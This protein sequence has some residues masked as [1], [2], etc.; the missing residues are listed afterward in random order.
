MWLTRVWPDACASPNASERDPSTRV[1][2]VLEPNILTCVFTCVLQC[3]SVQFGGDV[4]LNKCIFNINIMMKK[5]RWPPVNVVLGRILQLS[6]SSV[7][8]FI[9]SMPFPRV[10]SFTWNFKKI[11]VNV[12]QRPWC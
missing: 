9:E 10:F 5:Y 8:S 11:P 2:L 3:S 7:R 1:R 6:S 12:V 4:Q